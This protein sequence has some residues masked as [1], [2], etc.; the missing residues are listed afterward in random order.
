M[1]SCKEKANT[2]NVNMFKLKSDRQCA[3]LSFSFNNTCTH[4]VTFIKY[5]CL[6]GWALQ[7]CNGEQG[8]YICW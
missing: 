3:A 6:T 4:K 2:V 1:G 7:S 5:T 8:L